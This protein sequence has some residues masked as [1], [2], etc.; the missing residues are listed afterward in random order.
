M[1]GDGTTQAVTVQVAAGHGN[2]V[3]SLW[4][5]IHGLEYAGMVSIR[6]NEGPWIPL[7]NATATV[8]EP[9]KSYGGIGGAI[10]TLKLT[11][12]LPA[13]AVA[14]GPNTIHFRFNGTNG[15][16]SGFRVLA[17]N[18]VEPDGRLVL[19][20]E[21]F[22]DEDPNTWEPPFRDPTNIAAGRA[23]WHDAQLVASGLPNAQSI[24]AHCSDCHT[25]D[26]RDLK[27]FNFSNRSIIARSQFHGLSQLQGQQIAS[28]IRSL[29]VPNPGR[30]WNPPYQPGPGLDVQPEA[31]WAAGAGLQWVLENDVDALPF[32]FPRNSIGN[33]NPREIPIAF[34]LPDWNHWLPRV[35]P[36]DARGMH[37]RIKFPRHLSPGSKKWPPTAAAQ[38][39][40]NIPDSANEVGGSAI[41]K[42]Y[43]DNA[44]YEVDLLVNGGDPGQGRPV[45]HVYFLRRFLDL[46]RLSNRPE[47]ARLLIAII[48]AMQSSD[49]RPD[50]SI[51]PRIMVDK[52]WAPMFAL[53]PYSTKRAITESLL[54]AWLD[55]TLQRPTASYFKLGVPA[56]SYS[57]L[58]TWDQAAAQFKA[59]GV[60]PQ[61][62]ERLEAWS[63]DYA[64]LSTLFHY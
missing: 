29:P 42:E 9:A 31:N 19:P 36:L 61:L 24:R 3:R 33:L 49:W 38:S 41:T 23:V 14:D 63:R 27:Y 18:F 11:V 12:P 35:H 10:A 17:F 26:G 34:P 1:V 6:V 51:D 47:P 43:F 22:V 15:I 54:T 39:T 52:E 45:D 64:S 2:H 40:L 48:K 37:S 20:S 7:N 25:E 56:S 16:V 46:Q 21:S 57:G 8:A 4:M 28:Y 62:M 32:I 50:Q 53:L 59:A 5:Q 60:S 58:P 44:W 13:G 55:K 30:P